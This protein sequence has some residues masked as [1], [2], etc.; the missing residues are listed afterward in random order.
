MKTNLG[1]VFKEKL[2]LKYLFKAGHTNLSKVEWKDCPAKNSLR[3]RRELIR[4]AK[5]SCLGK[6]GNGWNWRVRFY[7]IL[8][9]I[10]IYILLLSMTGLVSDV[11][12]TYFIFTLS[13]SPRQLS[14]SQ[15]FVSKTNISPHTSHLRMPRY[16]LRCRLVL[17]HKQNIS[18]HFHTHCWG[19]NRP[20]CF[21]WVY[22]VIHILE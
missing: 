19:W 13:L 10:Y 9:F 2:E 17:F 1:E 16:C 11:I 15:F 20:D 3:F 7:T 5:K 6:R 18:S 4:K 12:E 14:I 22:I 8:N 21:P